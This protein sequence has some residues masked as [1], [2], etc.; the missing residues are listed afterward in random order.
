M[1]E[2][3]KEASH[4]KDLVPGSRMFGHKVGTEQR[5]DGRC[6]LGMNE[7]RQRCMMKWILKK[8]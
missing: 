3:V 6:R 8:G 7:K 5:S 1:L 4:I 2:L